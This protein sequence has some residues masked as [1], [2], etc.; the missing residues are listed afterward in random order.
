[1]D[2]RLGSLISKTGGSRSSPARYDQMPELSPGDL[3]KVSPVQLHTCL[4]CLRPSGSLAL[5]TP[6]TCSF[7]GSTKPPS[8][9]SSSIVIPKRRKRQTVKDHTESP[10]SGSSPSSTGT[11]YA[12]PSKSPV[13]EVASTSPSAPIPTSP[14]SLEP[15]YL[16]D[17]RPSLLS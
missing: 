17:R 10:A 5:Y 8:T 15:A 14:S 9:M 12:S 2:I 4:Y 16:R 6:C 7:S 1:L 13:K 3:D 11:S